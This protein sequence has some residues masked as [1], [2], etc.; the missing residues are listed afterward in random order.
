MKA[1]ANYEK[2]CNGLVEAFIRKHFTDKDISYEEIDWDWVGNS[3]GDVA[4][5]NGY[6][7]DI[8]LILEYMRQKCTS[9]QV[10]EY[11]D[12]AMLEYQASKSPLSL[13]SWLKSELKR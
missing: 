8:G 12:Y 10:F 6:F 3:I 2:A 4:H 5:V 13:T 9:D 11:Y 7:F 1:V